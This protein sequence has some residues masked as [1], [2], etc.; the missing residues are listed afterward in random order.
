MAGRDEP[1]GLFRVEQVWED[2]WLAHLDSRHVYD[3]RGCFMAGYERG[4]ADE[5][6]A[7]PSDLRAVELRAIAAEQDMVAAEAAIERGRAAVE[8]L[9]VLEKD[10]GSAWSDPIEEVQHRVL[11]ASGQRALRAEAKIA[12]VREWAEKQIAMGNGG[13]VH[14]ADEVLALLDAPEGGT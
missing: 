5:R 7:M 9:A 1:L 13:W 12:A 4:R 14:A 8:K 2:W 11:Q 10:F 3:K 6:D